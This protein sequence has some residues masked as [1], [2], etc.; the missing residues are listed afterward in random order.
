MDTAQALL[1]A[2]IQG[3][4]EFLP[5]SSSAHLIL[6][7]QVLGWPDQGLAFDVAVHL[8]SLCAV[9][10]AMRQEL[11]ELTGGVLRGLRER[12]GNRE[13][14]LVIW[15][16]LGTLPVI[17]A[18][19]ALKDLV[20]TNLRSVAVI[21]T[22]TIVFGL[23]LGVA[24]RR[25]PTSTRDEFGLK[26]G[27]V[28]LIGA[29]Q[30]LALIPG[31]SRSGITMTAGLMLGLSRSASARFSFLLSI[32]TIAGAGTL[33][34]LDL[35]TGDA[36]VDWVALGTGFAASALAAWACIHFFLALLE[37]TGFMPYVLYR[38]ALGALLIAFLV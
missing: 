36:A 30:C 27:D 38:L 35:V 23:L 24:D 25:R 12:R 13:S 4:T 3:V 29:A 19:L 8:G 9:L 11:V 31:T 21:A 7:A 15:V 20:E 34:T 10:V 28:L 6:P 26:L 33:S 22:T 18:G 17:L 5:V 1:L 14:R 32:P 37:R 2:L 16:V